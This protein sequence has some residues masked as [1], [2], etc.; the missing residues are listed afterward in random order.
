MF[1]ATGHKAMFDEM[2]RV[3]LLDSPG[4]QLLS[5]D[6]TFQLG[7]FYVSVLSFKHVLFIKENPVIPVA[8]MF[9]ERKF[10]TVHEHF[11]EICCKLSPAISK[12]QKPIV[13]DE[14]RGIVNAVA[15]HLMSSPNLRCWN[16]IFR[17]AMRWLRAHGAP[18]LDVSVYLSDLRDLFHLSTREEYDDELAKMSKK[19]SAV[20]L[21]YY[22][23]NISPDIES[24]ARWAIEPLGVYNPFSGVTNNQAE[25]MNFVLKHLLNWREVP[26]DCIALAI[27]YKNPQMLHTYLANFQGPED[28]NLFR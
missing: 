12:T 27:H 23:A 5:Y 19:W 16:H 2:D 8:F 20:F 13:T 6:T 9:H 7:D 14:E 10:K 17:D 18:S 24:T 22:N 15:K 28:S 21:Q 1:V 26:I 4:A 25:G 11:F 3:L